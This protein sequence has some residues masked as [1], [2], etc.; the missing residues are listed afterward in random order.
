[1]YT[2]AASDSTALA[3]PAEDV[4]APKQITLNRRKVQE[5]TVAAGKSKAL[6][7]GTTHVGSVA[8]AALLAGK[9]GVRR[10]AAWDPSGFAAQIEPGRRA[11]TAPGRQLSAPLQSKPQ[12]CLSIRFGPIRAGGAC[13]L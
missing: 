7:F 8:L 13:C 12:L 3:Q 1:M 2:G 10:I 11:R 5:I 9:A 6:K 4:A